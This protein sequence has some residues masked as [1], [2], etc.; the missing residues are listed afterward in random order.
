MA[1]SKS[2]QIKN[3]ERKSLYVEGKRVGEQGLCNARNPYRAGNPWH[4][5]W[6]KGWV[7]GYKE[8]WLH[9]IAT[10]EHV[11]ERDSICIFSASLIHACT[12]YSIIE[13]LTVDG[14]SMR[15]AVEFKEECFKLL[16]EVNLKLKS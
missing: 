8:C 3:Q 1:K 5:A 15:Q 16:D 12:S 10:S 9:R 7:E 6:K 2:F 14:M 11:V 13:C 4:S